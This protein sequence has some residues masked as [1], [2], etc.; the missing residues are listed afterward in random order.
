VFNLPPHKKFIKKA[1][2]TGKS[3]R[4][5]LNGEMSHNVRASRK[6]AARPFPICE[7]ANEVGHYRPRNE[8][9]QHVMKLNREQADVGAKRSSRRSKFKLNYREGLAVHLRTRNAK[10][11]RGFPTG[12]CCTIVLRRFS[13][14]VFYAGLGTV[15]FDLST[16]I[17]SSSVD[18]ASIRD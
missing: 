5:I 7:D 15:P 2:P 6:W 9:P 4:A 10:H 8:H 17:F 3:G 12:A 14:A 11:A 1:R 16:S 18:N 13:R